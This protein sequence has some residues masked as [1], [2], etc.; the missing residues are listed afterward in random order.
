MGGDYARG[1]EESLGVVLTGQ[2]RD[3]YP[4]AY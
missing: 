4:E 1:G 3:E 2:I